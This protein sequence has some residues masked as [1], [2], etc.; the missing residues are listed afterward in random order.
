[1]KEASCIVCK[2]DFDYCELYC[3]ISGRGAN[4]NC[5]DHKHKL[6]CEKCGGFDKE[7]L[8][9]P[10]CGSTDITFP[11]SS[12]LGG[13]SMV[14]RQCHSCLRVFNPDGTKLS[15]NDETIT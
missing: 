6:I 2:E 3:M 10:H 8:K 13:N 12:V 15:F 11:T 1:M 9:C 4:S 7:D 14:Y 5:K